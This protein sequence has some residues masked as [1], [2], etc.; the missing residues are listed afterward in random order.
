MGTVRLDGISFGDAD[1]DALFR[2]WRDAIERANNWTVG[3]HA[4]FNAGPSG[5]TLFVKGGGG[6]IS[7]VVATGGI[8]AAPDAN[9]LGQGDAVLRLRNGAALIN[10]PTIK[11]YSNFSTAI[12]AGTRIEIAP[13]A[14]GDYKLVGS[15]CPV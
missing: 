9:T 2:E 1:L 4:E 3:G 6:T 11:V 7:A 5:N 10:G 14:G 8:T 15:D 13:E 12:P